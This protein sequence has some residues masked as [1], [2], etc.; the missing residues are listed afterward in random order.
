MQAVGHQVAVLIDDV[1]PAVRVVDELHAPPA[2][3]VEHVDHELRQ[4]VEV[5]ADARQQRVHAVL[6]D[7]E[8]AGH[9]AGR[10]H[11][12]VPVA[13]LARDRRRRVVAAR[14]EEDV[15]AMVHVEDEGAVGRLGDVA[16]RVG[17]A[18]DDAPAGQ[19]ASAVDRLE[20]QPDGRHDALQREAAV[21]V[22]RQHHGDVDDVGGRRRRRRRRRLGGGARHA[23][24][25]HSDDD[26]DG[27][28]RQHRQGRAAGQCGAGRCG[29]GRCGAVRGG[30]GRCGAVRGG[31]GRCGAVRGGAGRCGAVRGGAGRCG[32][33]RGGAGRC[34]AVRGGAGR[35]GAVRG[36][37][38][39]C[40]AVRGGAGRCGAVRGGAGRC[41]AV[42]GGDGAVR[43]G[44][45]GTVKL[46]REAARARSGDKA[47][48][49]RGGGTGAATHRRCAG[50]TR[51]PRN[52][53]PEHARFVTLNS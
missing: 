39:R 44:S 7:A 18:H 6:G 5:G 21:V 25:R 8:V 51:S 31:A 26:D 45:T 49:A 15:H 22:A 38:G 42:R 41:G 37:A 19:Q 28:R 24:Q 52:C 35:C 4:R 9:R 46:P 50:C 29:A 10:Q 23:P 53:A 30:A 13:D 33:V 2:V 48:D 32:A 40:G 11:R 43:T 34:G 17:G 36:G 12:Q 3:V 16:L 47:T 27:E 14:P 20:R 1:L